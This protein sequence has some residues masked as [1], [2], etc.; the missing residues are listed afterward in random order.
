MIMNANKTK[1]VLAAVLVVL[2]TL[3]CGT[4]YRTT[5]KTS[6]NSGTIRVRMKE[7]NGANQTK[8]EINED[9]FRESVQIQA[10]FSV[11]SGTC[12]AV[13]TGEEGSRVSLEASGGSPGQTQGQLITDGFGEIDLETNCQAGINLDL[14]IDFTR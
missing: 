5:Y 1:I 3:A 8:I 13:L 6:G 11:E 2:V 4:G 14:V 12:Q 9:Y 7:A 10:A